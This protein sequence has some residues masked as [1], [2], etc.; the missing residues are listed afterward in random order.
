MNTAD[1]YGQLHPDLRLIVK[2]LGKRDATTRLRALDEFCGFI[3]NHSLQDLDGL[4][5]VWPTLYG[6][7]I[8]DADKRV[9]DAC[10]RLHLRLTKLFHRQMAPTLKD[11]MGPWLCAYSDS[12]KDVVRLS[13]EAFDT[14]L[15][16]K[17]VETLVFCQAS[18][19]AY[20]STNILDQTPET[21]SDPR[22]NTVED[23][24]AKYIRVVVGSLEILSMLL[25]SL[26]TDQIQPALDQ[27]DA[28]LN[29]N[30]FWQCACS[31]FAQIRRSCYSFLKASLKKMPETF[32]EPRINVVSMSFVAKAFMD[33]EPST[34]IEMWEAIILLT[35]QYPQCWQIASAKKPV[36][37]KLFQFLQR[38]AY[39]S[40]SSSYP[41]LMP[42]LSVLPAWVFQ[43]SNFAFFEQFFKSFWDGLHNIMDRSCTHTFFT[44]FFECILYVLTKASEEELNLPAHV[45]KS[46]VT[47]H[48]SQP[49]FFFV[50]PSKFGDIKNKIKLED[51][52]SSICLFAL[53]LST[54]KSIEEFLPSLFFTQLMKY[55]KGFIVDYKSPI[56]SSS[57]SDA[58]YEVVCLN[59]ASLLVALDK[60][61]P[62]GPLAI[63]VS[64]TLTSSPTRPKSASKSP[65]SP[66]AAQSERFSRA[67]QDFLK[68]T[69]DSAL[70]SLQKQP[71]H[72]VANLLNGIVF[73]FGYF[74]VSMK[75]TRNDIVNF[76]TTTSGGALSNLVAQG[77]QLS[78]TLSQIYPS[79]LISMCNP[80]NP[81]VTNYI[82][83]GVM[84]TQAQE[85]WDAY[86][87]TTF[88]VRDEKIRFKLL[89]AMIIRVSKIT[90]IL[91]KRI[92]MRGSEKLDKFIIDQLQ[93]GSPSNS[94]YS[95]E[96]IALLI[97]CPVEVG[98]LTEATVTAIVKSIHSRFSS[99]LES[100]LVIRKSDQAAGGMNTARKSLVHVLSSKWISEVLFILKV[101]QVVIAT[102]LP[103]SRS[104]VLAICNIISPIFLPIIELGVYQPWMVAKIVW[105]PSL[106][107]IGVEEDVLFRDLAQTAKN[108]WPNMSHLYKTIQGYGGDNAQIL[109]DKCLSQWSEGFNRLDH[110][111]T[112][113]D[114]ILELRVFLTLVTTTLFT[115]SSITSNMQKSAFGTFMK[116][117]SS[118]SEAD[119]NI[120]YRVIQVVFRDHA[121]W[122]DASMPFFKIDERLTAVNDAMKVMVL[123]DKPKKNQS[124]TTATSRN[125]PISHLHAISGIDEN[126]QQLAGI[127]PM[128]RTNSTG[129]LITPKKT[130]ESRVLLQ[131]MKAKT[132]LNRAISSSSRLLTQS[133]TNLQPEAGN[134]DGTE[135]RNSETASDD[136]L[137]AISTALRNSVHISGIASPLTEHQSQSF[138]NDPVLVEVEYDHD[139]LSVYLR[140]VLLAIGLFKEDLFDPN[141]SEADVQWVCVELARFVNLC[142]GFRQLSEEYRDRQ[143][144]RI[145]GANTST[146]PI[147]N[148]RGAGGDDSFTLEY[149]IE[150]L[151]LPWNVDSAVS[152]RNISQEI[153]Q[154]IS[155]ALSKSGFSPKTI[156]KETLIRIRAA[157]QKKASFDSSVMTAVAFDMAL[158]EDANT[159][160]LAIRFSYIQALYSILEIYF[161]NVQNEDFSL[162]IHA[163]A[164]LQNREDTNSLGIVLYQAIGRH[165][166]R[167][168][169][170]QFVLNHV[171]T[172]VQVIGKLDRKAMENEDTFR[173]LYKLVTRLNAFLE[174]FYPLEHEDDDDIVLDISLSANDYGSDPII[175]ENHAKQILRA[176]RGMFDKQAPVSDA[177]YTL[178]MPVVVKVQNNEGQ[179]SDES[180]DDSDSVGGHPDTVSIVNQDP[181]LKP[182]Q[183]PSVASSHSPWAKV[184]KTLIPKP[185]T[186][187]RI[188]PPNSRMVGYTNGA[189][190]HLLR[191]L[192]Q[193]HNQPSITM[194][195]F[196][197]DL[198]FKWLNELQDRDLSQVHHLGPKT[199]GAIEAPYSAF[200]SRNARSG[201]KGQQLRAYEFFWLHRS[202]RL[203]LG[204]VGAYK[205]DAIQGGE[206]P[207]RYAQDM[208][209][210]QVW[211]SYLS[212]WL[213]ILDPFSTQQ[214]L[215]VSTT[216]NRLVVIE[217]DVEVVVDE[218]KSDCNGYQVYVDHRYMVRLHEPLLA[219][220]EAA[221]ELVMNLSV[222]S[223]KE[224]RDYLDMERLYY[225]L[226]QCP[227]E[228]TQ[229]ALY[230]ILMRLVMIGVE[231][232]S[233]AL[234]M[235]AQLQTQDNDALIED[236][237]VL[238]EEG[239]IVKYKISKAL[240]FG[241]RSIPVTSQIGSERS[242]DQYDEDENVYHPE[243]SQKT[244]IGGSE[245]DGQKEQDEILA[246]RFAYLASWRLLL[247]HFHN[248][249]FELKSGYLSYLRTLQV[250]DH[251]V[252][253]MQ[254]MQQRQSVRS[255]RDDDKRTTDFFS[256]FV[257]YLFNMLGVGTSSGKPFDLSGW[258]IADY[259]IDGYNATSE[260]SIQLL[261][262]H[263]YWCVLRHLPTLMRTWWNECKNRQ[264]TLAVEAFTERF[265]SPRLIAM[266]FESLQQKRK[267]ADSIQDGKV[268]LEED[269]GSGSMAIRV[270]KTMNEV[271]ASYTIEDASLELSI[272][273]P[274]CYPLRHVE[275]E[276]K[277]GSGSISGSGG[278]ASNGIAGINESRWRAWLLGV[279]STIQF[280]NGS[281]LDALKVFQRNAKMHFDGIED[282]AICYSVIS[283]TDRS[284]PTKQ[285]RTCKH[286]FHGSCLFKW[287]KSSNQSSCPLCRQPF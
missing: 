33:S 238:N 170:N 55:T 7:F 235:K 9:R 254:Q 46:L 281:I 206:R 274:S 204:I 237:H 184:Q 84:S 11:L 37:N 101:L 107:E 47:S 127:N 109:V 98:I 124:A 97:R 236:E 192:I 66:S 178:E 201:L 217:Q 93:C 8:I 39:G 187:V 257:V 205:D 171:D 59:I 17:R 50:Q 173:Q 264:L 248:A 194:V 270:A 36:V 42:L 86:M 134:T 2:R 167:H 239:Q 180:S 27:Y 179:D 193:I 182:V 241:C 43:E 259:D 38:G 44:S 255:K 275:V 218:D 181:P 164:S 1:D 260:L 51:I 34:H 125:S 82:D 247:A 130:F 160:S 94:Q 140:L 41:C 81:Y 162:W 90:H 67:F 31:D 154:V 70:I 88:S 143:V 216:D 137:S 147:Y 72:N 6:R 278:A 129:L 52:E 161:S 35:R 99:I 18:L 13:K 15:P 166:K 95:A 212:I 146:F 14:M 269:S 211:K 273:L 92:D 89:H 65:S 40:V 208:D 20:V 76:L 230:S 53:K 10:A 68:S 287:F 177:I 106:E 229:R 214:S 185:S 5:P 228:R 165:L 73:N 28:L 24:V 21:L 153:R 25:D 262:A 58:E 198:C 253:R 271:T 103:T 87:G 121:Y 258:D 243:K 240:E 61:R 272:K 29:H 78:S 26:S 232:R 60:V 56:D 62:G 110:C 105:D 115:E 252:G 157:S 284:L 196:I 122:S 203:W 225:C 280:Q 169:L 197:V 207:W 210:T 133:A 190:A 123:V 139:G 85:L 150:G 155:A 285:C 175:C 100:F 151:L 116:R 114:F 256:D 226:V 222:S 234:E 183:E 79:L 242:D 172:I 104:A 245:S 30:R 159:S 163:E 191:I 244:S 132:K 266:E 77:T 23:M 233:L 96:C 231:E 286:R 45:G 148:K 221:S 145:L 49:V 213:R 276:T 220:L 91:S 4:L 32:I 188:T 19:I 136:G 64:S 135:S 63:P 168:P 176:I 22:F 141:D 279:S 158:K 156:A 117:R 261:C 263:L 251:R 111:G 112:P 48:A 126:T 215:V 223:N 118:I 83:F 108:M 174:S 200:E 142:D 202:L 267:G 282:C 224:M 195:K 199:L 268:L 113:A 149:R 128:L 131:E 119:R 57:L 80:E 186:P 246:Q 249:T 250:E 152:C 16:N 71:T 3:D 75:E 219:I 69:V 283:A 54:L 102:P 265:Y 12:S 277:K 209:E 189:V 74:A 138:N 120:V 227:N 144:N